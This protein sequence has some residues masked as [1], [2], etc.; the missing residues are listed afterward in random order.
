MAVE[1][2][3]LELDP[4][5][6]GPLGDEPHLDL[7]ALLRVGLE[8]PGGADV[9]AEDHP[10]GRLVDQDAGPVALAAVDPAV[11]DA[12]S[13]PGL[14]DGL[15]DVDGEQVVVPRLDPVQLLGEDAER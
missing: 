7:A 1:V 2:A 5:A 15:L 4:S 11:V 14:E 3:V 9:P 6:L 13:R 12:A 10:V 8:L